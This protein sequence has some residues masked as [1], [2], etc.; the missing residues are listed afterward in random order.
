MSDRKNENVPG[1]ILKES[2]T[3]AARDNYKTLQQLSVEYGITRQGVKA[4]LN[5]MLAE[6]KQAGEDEAE[7]IIRGKQNTIYVKPKGI[8]W[9]ASWNN[10][11][12][13]M[14]VPARNIDLELF[15][16]QQAEQTA[17]DLRDT[18]AKLEKQIER[19]EDEKTF[20]HDQITYLNK[21]IEVL[22][23]TTAH[24]VQVID[25]QAERIL[26][27]TEVKE[28]EPETKAPDVEPSPDTPQNASEASET[29]VSVS[30]DE[31]R[32]GLSKKSFW[33]KLALLFG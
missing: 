2:T 8:D 4:R 7:Y 14:Q 26:A 13:P 11:N 3:K 24:Q 32:A 22:H 25:F 33:G 19:N 1:E 16:L 21:Q 12:T 18:I 27:L 20:L 5:K 6:I 28:P 10:A 15:K 23:A 9:L 30:D 17:Q 29:P 31:L